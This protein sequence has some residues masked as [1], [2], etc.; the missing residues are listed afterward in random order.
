MPKLKI[1]AKIYAVNDGK[2]SIKAFANININNLVF[3]NSFAIS[4]S[5]E[6]PEKLSVFPPSYCSRGKYHPVMEFPYMKNNG[7]YGA[8]RNAC[9]SAYKKYSDTGQSH[10]DSEPFE[11]E[12]DIIPT[13]TEKS[14]Q[15]Q[16]EY[17]QDILPTD[18]D[19][20]SFDADNLSIPFD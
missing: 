1:T 14:P 3:I 4:N 6:Q 12:Y 15:N 7:L 9:L 5:A 19:V 17:G 20:D 8:I 11:A 18:E 13:S 2:T 10:V 16:A